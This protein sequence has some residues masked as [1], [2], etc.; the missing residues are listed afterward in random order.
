M[1]SIRGTDEL[2]AAALLFR[3]ADRA[4]RAAI[5]KESRQW[6]PEL[7]RAAQARARGRVDRR[8]ANSGR[9]TTTARGLKATFGASGSLPSGERLAE[10]T[11]PFEFGTG[12]R[13]AKKTYLSRQRTSKRRMYVTR[14]TQRQIPRRN[15]K[16]RFLYPAVADVT[17]DLVARWVRAIAKAVQR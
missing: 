12:N 8:I 11:R 9:T 5:A 1:L 2:K 16:G 4:T 15:D 17:P 10:V 13:E 7:K 14:R 3:N 6:S